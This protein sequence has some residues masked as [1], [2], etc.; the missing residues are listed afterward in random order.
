MLIL[1]RKDSFK[2]MKLI[3]MYNV[4]MA[5][6]KGRSFLLMIGLNN[7]FYF[8]FGNSFFFFLTVPPACGILVPQPGIKTPAP[9]LESQNLNHW[10]ARGNLFFLI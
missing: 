9:A 8:S 4:N 3:N 10:T 1:S 6:F 2:K 7:F 5:L